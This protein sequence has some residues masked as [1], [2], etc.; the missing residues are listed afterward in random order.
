MRPFI[1][2]GMNTAL[3]IEEIEGSLPMSRKEFLLG[4]IQEELD[5][6]VDFRNTDIPQRKSI[7]EFRRFMIQRLIT[8]RIMNTIPGYTIRV[9]IESLN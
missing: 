5:Q 2:K 9:E 8:G 3:F 7:R 4:L 1:K 6:Y